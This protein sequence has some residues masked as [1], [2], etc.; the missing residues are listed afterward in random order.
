MGQDFFTDSAKY[1]Y[2]SCLISGHVSGHSGPKVLLGLGGAGEMLARGIRI[3]PI[4][5]D[6][7]YW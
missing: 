4:Y 7:K 3:Q 1:D 5:P 2:M 6:P